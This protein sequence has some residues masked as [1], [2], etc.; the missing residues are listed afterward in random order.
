M[1][2]RVTV[3]PRFHRSFA[4][5]LI[6][7]STIGCSTAPVKPNPS[8]TLA[9]MPSSSKT[10]INIEVDSRFHSRSK[11]LI[12]GTFGTLAGGAAVGATAG[13]TYCGYYRGGLCGLFGQFSEPLVLHTWG[14][15]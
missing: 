1:F 2:S 12:G 15:N 8:D 14:V 7:L 3:F 4:T 11:S 5:L 13:K 6:V 9:T 10:A